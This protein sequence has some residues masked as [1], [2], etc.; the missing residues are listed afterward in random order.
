MPY[1]H[2]GVNDRIDIFLHS[3]TTL[4]SQ[5][6]TTQLIA[7]FHLLRL[8]LLLL[9]LPHQEMGGALPHHHHH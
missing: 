8:Q 2:D 5:H 7:Q 1:T 4:A 6:S 3:T 9:R